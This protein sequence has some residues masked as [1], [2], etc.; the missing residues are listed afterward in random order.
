MATRLA[1]DQRRRGTY[2]ARVV[3]AYLA[4]INTLRTHASRVVAMAEANPRLDVLAAVREIPV[5]QVLD[6]TLGVTVVEILEDGGRRAMGAARKEESTVKRTWQEDLNERLGILDQLA[7][8]YA[9]TQGSH[10]VTRVTASVRETI[11]DAIAIGVRDNQAIPEIARAVR[12]TIGM[13]PR[14]ASAL[15]RMRRELRATGL[16]AAKTEARI[17][18]RA[19]A[20]LNRRARS[21]ARTEVQFAMNEARAAEWASAVAQG[22]LPRDMRRIWIAKDPC[23]LCI[24]LAEHPSVALD[25]PFIDESGESVMRPPRHTNC[26]CSV[27][28][29]RA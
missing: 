25:E 8:D 16:S 7:H 26:R 3:R 4:A 21:I 5:E 1:A 20:M 14:D 9:V 15:G 11:R 28:L 18:R 29:V 10:L 12:N 2:E 17:A 24:S 19:G 6:A 23:D 13:L 22:E 27:A